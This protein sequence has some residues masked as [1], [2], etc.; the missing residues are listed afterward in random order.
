MPLAVTPCGVRAVSLLRA[1]AVSRL[2]HVFY[3]IE[4]KFI[5]WNNAKPRV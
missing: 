2:F 4:H 1:M 5:G 3:Q